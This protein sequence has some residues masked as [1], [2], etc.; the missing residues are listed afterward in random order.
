M[1]TA[2]IYLLVMLLVAAVVFLLA[3]LV[4]GR[5]EELAPLAA[6]SSPTRLPAEDI[7]AE[8][9]EA[10]KYQIVVRGYKMSE[11]DWVMA[12]LGTEIDLLRAR[13]AELETAHAGGEVRGE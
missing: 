3:S 11:V 2:L 10:V 5:G 4:F 7:T 12:R 8:D 13:V 6:G 1:T 9:V